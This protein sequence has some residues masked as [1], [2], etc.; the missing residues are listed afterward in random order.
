M[1]DKELRVHLKADDDI[2]KA[3]KSAKSELDRIPDKVS[4]TLDVDSSGLDDLSGKLGDLPGLVGDIAGKMAGPG[5][6]AAAAGLAGAAVFDLAQGFADAAVEARVTADLTGAS[7]EDASRLQAVWKQSG[8]DINDLNDVLLQMNGVLQTSPDLARQIGVNLKDGADVG[9][10]FVEVVGKIQSSTLGASDKAQLMSQ[11]FGEEGVRQVAK[12]T[13]SIDGPLS[14]AIEDVSESQIISE[15]EEARAKRLTEQTRKLN[16]EWQNLK[17]TLGEAFVGPVTTSIEKTLAPLEGL[18]AVLGGDWSRVFDTSGTDAWRAS[19]EGGVAALEAAD[20]AGGEFGRKVGPAIEGASIAMAGMTGAV[21]EGADA[22]KEADENTA[23][24]GRSIRE[25]AE[26]ARDLMNAEQEAA[27]TRRAMV[28]AEFAYRDAQRDVV[29]AIEDTSKALEESAPA[30]L[31]GAA[32]LDEF[33]QTTAA[34]ADAA[35]AWQAEQLATSGATQSA[36]DAQSAW[37]ADML[38]SAR[39]LSGPMRQAIVDYIAKING[40]PPEKVSEILANPD[41]VTIDAANAAIDKAAADETARITAEAETAQAARE[42]DEIAARKRT[43]V[44]QATVAYRENVRLG[45]GVGMS[46][47]MAPAAVGPQATATIPVAVPAAALAP[48]TVKVPATIT[49]TI[50]IQAG[51]VG[52]RFDTERAVTKALRRHRRLN[53]LRE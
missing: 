30:T 17:M 33:A 44:I 12:L 38:N 22:I 1:A 45:G 53:G 43:A 31:A 41:Y 14:Q 6:I 7:I 24:Y 18:K 35:V 40:I 48:I 21:E 20:F 29:T 37:N 28:D 26:A 15:E 27:D 47:A 42:L 52:N 10:R 23:S 34:A 46:P 2:S 9:S 49:P 32:A 8:A 3:A 25:T 5:G 11:M 4:T 36:A 39:N 51:V 19:L 16:T 50:V 13:A